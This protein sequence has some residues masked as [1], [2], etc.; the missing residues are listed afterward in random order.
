VVFGLLECLKEI[1]Y[2]ELQKANFKLSVNLSI[3]Q[4]NAIVPLADLQI[5]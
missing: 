3:Y 4:F 1:F 5:P 2:Q